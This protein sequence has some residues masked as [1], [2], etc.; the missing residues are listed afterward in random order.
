MC[1]EIVLNSFPIVPTVFT[2]LTIATLMYKNYSGE[3]RWTLLTPVAEESVPQRWTLSKQHVVLVDA[4]R[5]RFS[6][7]PEPPFATSVSRRFCGDPRRSVA[8]ID[9]ES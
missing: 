5:H 3:F 8:V 2:R 4:L 7:S 6:T 1:Y 9:D